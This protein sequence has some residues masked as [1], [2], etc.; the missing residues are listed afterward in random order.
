MND[1][2][3]RNEEISKIQNIINNCEKSSSTINIYGSSG[4][5]KTFLIKKTIGKYF[6]NKS[7]STIIYINLLDDILWTTAFWDMI[8]FTVWNGNICDNTNMIK[9]DRKNSMA[10]Y[11]KR[12]VRGRKIFKTLLNSITSI[13][14]TIPV[15][16]AQLEVGGMGNNISDTTV[17]VNT[18]IEKSQIVINYFKYITKKNKLI[19]IIDNYQFM[20]STIKRYFETSINQITK[21]IAF[22]N[23]QRTDS[24]EFVRPI[25]YQTSY[26]DVKL[27]NLDKNEVFKSILNPLY[28]DIAI[29]NEVLED[30]YEKTSGNLKEIE[31]YL[32]SNDN[33]IR[34]GILKKNKTKSLHNALNTLPQIQR[35]LVLLATLF[36]AGIRLEYV[37]TLMKK[38]FYFND[39]VLNK[40]LKK[41]VTLG[42]VMLN[43]TRKDLLK[44]SHDKIGLSIETISST[45]EFIE[46]YQNVEEGL[47]ELV[48]QKK[49]SS[50]YI[51]LLHCYVGICDGKRILR[52]I[53][54]LEKLITIKYEAC[55]FLYIVELTENYLDTQKDVLL[56]LSKHCILYMLDACQKTCSFNISLGILNIIKNSTLWDKHFSIYYVKV[57]TQ[58]YHFDTALKEIESL[59]KNNE[60]LMYKLIILEHL[61]KED[62]AKKLLDSFIK[63]N[64][65][66]H[67][68]WYY[69]ILRNTAHFFSYD[70]AYLNL[71]KC[72]EYF[73][74]CG[75]VFEQATVLNN[76]SV[77]QIWN[78]EIT[79]VA[80][81]NTIKKAIEK[82]NQINSNEIFESYYNYGTLNY[83]KGE[84][85]EAYEYFKLALSEVPTSL[86]MDV[87]LLNLSKK[88]CECTVDASKISDLEKYILQ[89]LNKPEI[90]QDPWVAFQLEY[91]LKNIEIFLKG[92]S[93][94]YPC[95]NF[96]PKPEKDV[97]SL[98]VF[99]ELKINESIN[100]PICLSLSPNWRY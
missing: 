53:K 95:I 60:T 78:G 72:L 27:Q 39:D 11:L 38:F 66:V 19:L 43:S 83:L 10:Y 89:S 86:E 58:L 76:I 79:R 46:F 35:D 30:C 93:D 70:Q 65:I 52:S 18:E 75:T 77:I 21:N 6:V 16:N 81:E 48:Q 59:P 64:N 7:G 31:I 25:A 23:L 51:Y 50:D 14:A 49:E 45:E 36:P 8:L 62:E 82:F 97:T 88:I 47:E 98:T 68:K 61:C 20:N 84:Y 91:N 15:Y 42:Y 13:V 96:L 44:L 57:M 55:S 74:K 12:S 56:N 33:N 32:S 2:N 87:T 3:I 63:S 94:I 41:I 5:G 73:E 26:Y 29:L 67:D 9:I 4:T 80:A 92:E 34:N 85:Q 90:L 40:E 37:T 69:I 22:I 54:Y 100:I 1:Y 24:V 17:N 99:S 28:S 71:K